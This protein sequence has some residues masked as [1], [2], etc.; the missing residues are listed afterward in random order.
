MNGKR[1]S[2][3]KAR[4]NGFYLALAVCLV[5]VGI[6]AWSTYDA[7]NG[8]IEPEESGQISSL[9]QQQNE[10]VRSS[11]ENSA[12]A[13][14]VDDDPEAPRAT[15]SS[16]VKETN[17]SAVSGAGE[18]SSQPPAAQS[19]APEGVSQQEEENQVPVNAPLYEISPELVY[20]VESKE[21]AKVYS[22]GAPVY[23]ETMKDWRIHSGVD[24]KAE[25]G[26]QA[27]ACGNGLVTET[28]TDSM[29]GNVVIIEHGDYKISYCG[30]GEDFQVKAGD[31][32]SKGQV[33]GTVTA[34][35]SESAEEPHLHLEIRRDNACMDP[36]KV[37]EGNG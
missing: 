30:L 5:A 11:Q 20:P 35:P 21:I 12:T 13:P 31:V 27:F 15:P 23:S 14:D 34:V 24:I 8:Y 1:S 7:V 37:I 10:D 18:S 3:D 26:E 36:Q 33:I 29:L 9:S 19:S 22:A 16:P 32:V 4:R 2:E 17:A 25:S 6:A 28:Y